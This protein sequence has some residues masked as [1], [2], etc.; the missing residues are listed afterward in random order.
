[1]TSHASKW[2]AVIL[3][4]LGA[5]SCGMLS[6]LIKMAYGRGLAANVGELLGWGLHPRFARVGA[7]DALFQHRHSED[8]KLAGGDARSM[9]LPVALLG[10]F[11]ILGEQML[12]VQWAGMALILLGIA[13]SETGA[14]TPARRTEAD[15]RT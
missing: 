4:L 5:S 15:R 6:P 8:R 9:E 1:M 7:A 3:V 12:P 2:V 14:S 11:F 10:A 13:V